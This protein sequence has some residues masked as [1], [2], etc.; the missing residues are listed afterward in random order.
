KGFL[1]TWVRQHPT[2]VRLR[3]IGAAVGRPVHVSGWD[4]KERA[5][6]PSR[7]LAPSGS[8]YFFEIEEGDDHAVERFIDE[9]WLTPI[10][11]GE[12]DRRDGFGVALLG[13]WKEENHA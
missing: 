5:P 12:Q 13:V 8:V 11:D 4:Y 3:I 2:G 10:S 7:R 9:V 6:K 1:P